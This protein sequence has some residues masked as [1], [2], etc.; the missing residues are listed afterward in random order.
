MQ[1]V[2]AAKGA[3]LLFGWESGGNLSTPDTHTHTLVQHSARGHGED[4][5]FHLQVD[6]LPSTW[7]WFMKMSPPYLPPP[8][9]HG[10]V[11]GW[12]LLCVRLTLSHTLTVVL[13][14]QC[15]KLCV[16]RDCGICLPASLINDKSPCIL[17]A[18]C[19]CLLT[20]DGTSEWILLEFL[21]PVFP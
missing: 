21:C 15:V 9:S 11:C 20:P 17:S 16:L 3:S 14:C 18:I 1:S 10:V 5:G 6:G 8:P 2:T 7:Y 19:N 12:D 13:S 4:G